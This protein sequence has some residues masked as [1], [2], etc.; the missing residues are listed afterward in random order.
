MACEE[1]TDKEIAERTR[2]FVS[3]QKGQETIREALDSASKAAQQIYEAS[4]VDPKKLD[5]PITL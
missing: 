3:S 1:S 5:E 2:A 4:E